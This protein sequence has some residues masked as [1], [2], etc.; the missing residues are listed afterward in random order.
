MPKSFQRAHANNLGRAQRRLAH[1]MSE[2]T[3]PC[4]TT[5]CRPPPPASQSAVV[6]TARKPCGAVR[7][8]RGR[9]LPRLYE[10]ATM[11]WEA[12]KEPIVMAIGVAAA[13]AGVGMGQAERPSPEQEGGGGRAEVSPAQGDNVSRQ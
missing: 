3:A 8:S 9:E 12:L 1:S 11:V 2:S 6:G 4:C 13:R 10:P 5:C 7:E